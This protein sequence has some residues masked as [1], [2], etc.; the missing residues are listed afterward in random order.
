MYST[1]V[2]EDTTGDRNSS[3]TT[4]LWRHA[5]FQGLTETREA[6]AEI[7]KFKQGT[8]NDHVTM[9]K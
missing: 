2:W 8:Y 5:K 6:D 1:Y 4:S 9:C 7:R 3:L